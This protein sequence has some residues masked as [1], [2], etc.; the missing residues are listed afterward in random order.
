MKAQHALAYDEPPTWYY[1]VRETLGAA[2]LADGK[3]ADAE[4]V[5]REDLKY[6]PGNGRSMFGVW[7]SLEARKKTVAATLARA[8]FQLVWAVADVKL[9]VEDL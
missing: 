4:A 2:L 7:K 8:A 1:P 6:N 9:R 3:A 5:F